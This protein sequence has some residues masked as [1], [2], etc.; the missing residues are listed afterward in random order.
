M[1]QDSIDITTYNSTMTNINIF[2]K[3]YL[4]D[5]CCIWCDEYIWGLFGG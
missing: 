4:S 3:V 2:A 5:N 1:I